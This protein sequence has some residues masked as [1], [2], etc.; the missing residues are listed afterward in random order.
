M[1]QL[2]LALQWQHELL[3]SSMES[4]FSDVTNM[5]REPRHTQTEDAEEEVCLPA[6]SPAV[7]EMVSADGKAPSPITSYS[8]F[9]GARSSRV[10]ASGVKGLQRSAGDQESLRLSLNIVDVSSLTDCQYH[11]EEMDQRSFG[12][13]SI[14]ISP[15]VEMEPLN[16]DIE[17]KRST[18]APD[19][20]WLSLPMDDLE[21]LYTGMG[22]P[23]P[24]RTDLQVN[25]ASYHHA[26]ADPTNRSGSQH[27]QT[28]VDPELSLNNILPSTNPDGRDQS[29][30]STNLW[31]SYHHQSSAADRYSSTVALQKHPNSDPSLNRCLTSYAQNQ[32]LSK[33]EK[34]TRS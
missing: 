4:H 20:P 5:P 24:Q 21:N 23:K 6:T 28:D 1:E 32:I 13:S 29:I 18:A 25:E 31:D 27:P 12:N 22:T 19:N 17:V 34:S 26:A 9:D 14:Q 3:H 16:V 30:F 10:E 2:Q 33:E 8:G 15:K 11:R 7:S